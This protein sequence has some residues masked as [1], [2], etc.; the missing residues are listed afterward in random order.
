MR[1][2]PRE[3][4]QWA[5]LAQLHEMG[6][7]HKNGSTHVRPKHLSLAAA[8]ATK[9]SKSEVGQ[10]PQVVCRWSNRLELCHTKQKADDTT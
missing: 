4:N 9:Q 8:A 1:Q 2:S 7:A 3:S 5:A 10:H 6:A